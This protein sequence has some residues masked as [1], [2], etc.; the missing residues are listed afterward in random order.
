MHPKG[1]TPHAHVARR[2]RRG[3]RRQLDGPAAIG[4]IRDALCRRPG[5]GRRVAAQRTFRPGAGGR[6]ARP[7]Q[8]VRRVRGGQGVRP[9]SRRHLPHGLRRRVQHRGRPRHGRRRLHRQALPRPR[10][11]LAHPLG[12]APHERR[13]VAFALG[14]RGDRRRHRVRAQGG[15]RPGADGARVPAA[16]AV[17]AEPGQAGHARAR[18]QRH[19]GQR[20]RIRQRQHAERLRQAPARQGGGRSGRTPPHPHRARAGL[21]DGGATWA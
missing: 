9:G 13:L 4:R 6:G 11:A 18:A 3:H 5:R 14:R 15:P 19:L 17:R 2:R 21:P 10:A 20:R 12:A 16:P 8:R 1:R 7:G